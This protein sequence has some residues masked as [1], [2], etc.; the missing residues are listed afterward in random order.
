MMP[1]ICLKD[2]P[3]GSHDFGCPICKRVMLPRMI[4]NDPRW[5]SRESE[6]NLCPICQAITDLSGEAMDDYQFAIKE[7]HKAHKIDEIPRPINIYQYRDNLKTYLHCQRLGKPDKLDF[8]VERW[9]KKMGLTLPTIAD[10][11]TREQI[12]ISKRKNM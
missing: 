5:K 3:D 8:S 12:I 2:Y 7:W 4:F 6:Y 11:Y 9:A 1:Y 10:V